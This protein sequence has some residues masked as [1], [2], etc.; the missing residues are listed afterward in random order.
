MPCSFVEPAGPGLLE[1]DEEEGGGGRRGGGRG[2]RDHQVQCNEQFE[3]ASDEKK[4]V[5]AMSRSKR[6][7][8]REEASRRERCRDGGW[9]DEVEMSEVK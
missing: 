3:E 6:S 1:R 9:G 4:Q 2:G 7:E 8:R 5:G